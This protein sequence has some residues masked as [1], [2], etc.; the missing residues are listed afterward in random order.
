MSAE[1]VNIKLK[2]GQ[3]AY[4]I[5]GEYIMRY[6]EY[7][8]YTTV[9]VS[10]GLSYDGVNYSLYKE[11]AYPDEAGDIEYLNDWHEG[12]RFIKLFGIEAV[13]KLDV[14]GGIYEA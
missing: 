12:E 14:Y 4:D 3:N 6:W 1:T 8:I 7:N 13:D 10:V 2:D 5:V 11:V 9:I